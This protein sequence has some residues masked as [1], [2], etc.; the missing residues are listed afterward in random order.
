MSDNFEGTAR[1]MG[2]RVELGADVLSLARQIEV[3]VS[4]AV[5]LLQS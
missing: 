3:S 4:G 5:A 2:G 1:E